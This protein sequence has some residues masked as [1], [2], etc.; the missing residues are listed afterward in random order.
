MVFPETDQ[1]EMFR[2]IT[3]CVIRDDLL[4][5]FRYGQEEEEDVDFVILS[6]VLQ[7]QN[8]PPDEQ[9]CLPKSL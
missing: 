7:K 4:R 5:I 3:E 9:V 8:L 2:K 6:T 1:E